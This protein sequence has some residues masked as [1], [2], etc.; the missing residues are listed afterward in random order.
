M[1]TIEGLGKVAQ[2]ARAHRR[3]A[4]KSVVAALREVEVHWWFLSSG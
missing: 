3:L 4:R 2:K 1:I